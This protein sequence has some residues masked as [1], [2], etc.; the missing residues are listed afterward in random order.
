MK[1]F[2]LFVALFSLVT[3]AKAWDGVNTETGNEV[4]IE[5]GNLVRT[6][7]D[8]ELYDSNSGQY[9]DMSV[10]SI[11]RVGNS[12]EIEMYNNETGETQTY[13]FDDQ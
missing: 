12:V 8:I 3:E 10:E 13:E 1:T 5:Q 7:R 2:V 4:T 6:G 11:N 9:I